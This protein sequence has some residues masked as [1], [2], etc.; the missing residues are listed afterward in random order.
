M[1]AGTILSLIAWLEL[2]NSSAF[3]FDKKDEEPGS[4]VFCGTIWQR[5]DYTRLAITSDFF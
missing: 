5:Q 1:W 4:Y 2:D 3:S